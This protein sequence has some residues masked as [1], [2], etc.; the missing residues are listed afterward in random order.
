MNWLISVRR[1]VKR[2]SREI[3]P[4]EMDIHECG[5]IKQHH[6]GRVR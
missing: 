4:S 2:L 3:E 1:P 5:I 6:V